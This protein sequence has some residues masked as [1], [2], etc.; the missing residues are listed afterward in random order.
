MFKVIVALHK[1]AQE[2]FTIF[3]FGAIESGWLIVIS[4]VSEQP[5]KSVTA[6][7]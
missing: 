6:V 2:T 7:L 1:P 3:S 4:T 5:L